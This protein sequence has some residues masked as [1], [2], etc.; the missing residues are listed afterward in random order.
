MFFLLDMDASAVQQL[1]NEIE[2]LGCE[3]WKTSIGAPGVT[4]HCA[5]DKKVCSLDLFS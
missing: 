3:C 1:Q 4:L 2:Q 5:T